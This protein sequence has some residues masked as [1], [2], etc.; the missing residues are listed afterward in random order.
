MRRRTLGV[1]V[2]LGAVL[3]AGCST[4][5][6]S[7]AVSSDPV[8]RTGTGTA[9]VTGVGDGTSGD[10]H[11]AGRAAA[12]GTASAAPPSA[13]EPAMPGGSMAMC[14]NETLG[15]SMARTVEY[16]SAVALATGA[17]TGTTM[18]ADGEI[19][20]PY[21]EVGLTVERTLAGP[22]VPESLS[23]WVYGDLAAS[24]GSATTGETSSLWAR[25]GRMIAI[26]DTQTER[27]GLPGPV[28]RAAPVVGDELILS[29]V[30]CWSTTGVS[31][32]EFDGAV[33]IF[34]ERGRNPTELQLFAMSLTE[35]EGLLPG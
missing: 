25:G 29:W 1:L 20:V 18:L 16:G 33:D 19:G 12:A 15:E 27:S 35:F 5:G 8:T 30:G 23:A 24:G 21:S 22:A 10:P 3:V 31:T 9:T 14:A 6:T 34:D 4:P 28:I 11:A 2:L 13:Q 32:R 17:F 26:V 7:S